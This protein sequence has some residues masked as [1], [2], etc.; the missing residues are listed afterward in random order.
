[1]NKKTGLL[2]A[3]GFAACAA[4]PALAQQKK[5]AAPQKKKTSGGAFQKTPTGLQYKIVRD[6]PGVQKP[7]TGDYVEMHIR[8]HIG[9]SILFDSRKINNHQPVPFQLSKPSFKGDLVDGLAL[10]TV[11]DS[12]VFRIPLDSILQQGNQPLPWMK[13]GAG[14][15]V[16]Y[17]VVLTKVSTQEQLKKEQEEKS[18]KQKTIDEQ[19]LQDYFSKNNLQPKKTASGLYYVITAEGSGETARSGQT[20]TANYTGRTMDGNAFDSNLDPKF[21]HVQPFNFTLGQRQVI[22]GW[23]EGFGLLK[24]GGKATLYIPSGL[25]YGE[26]SPSPQIPA[27]AILIFDVELVDIK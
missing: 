23:D 15:M 16:Q 11:G 24:K 10:M 22:A 18:A 20:V 2:L 7:L 8:S 17:E 6:V 21:N 1:M 13:K 9:D 14:Q 12:A 3:L 25:A 5:P 27:N 26:R 19:L 4:Q